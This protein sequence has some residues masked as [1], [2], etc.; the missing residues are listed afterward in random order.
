MTEEEKRLFII[1]LASSSQCLV[2][3]IVN[4]LIFVVM[5]VKQQELLLSIQ[6]IRDSLVTPICN[7]IRY[8]QVKVV[9]YNLQC[10]CDWV[11]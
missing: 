6:T 7:R 1:S 2:L 11:W 4:L 8:I 5:M 10:S 3:A 9:Y